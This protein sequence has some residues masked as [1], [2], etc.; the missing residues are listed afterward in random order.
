MLASLISNESS[1]NVPS[2]VIFCVISANSKHSHGDFRKSLCAKSPQKRRFV[3]CWWFWLCMDKITS[4]TGESL[5]LHL[6]VWS[7]LEHCQL[8]FA[9]VKRVVLPEGFKEVLHQFLKKS[10]YKHR[11]NIKVLVTANYDLSKANQAK[12]IQFIFLYRRTNSTSRENSEI[13]IALIFVLFRIY[14]HMK[15]LFTKWWRILL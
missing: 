9:K 2:T 1:T 3:T 11:D 8:R 12:E 4:P 13:R 10:V 7:I 5:V 15:F 6:V 14:T